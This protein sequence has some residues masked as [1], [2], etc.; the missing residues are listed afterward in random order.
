M[1]KGIPYL[2]AVLVA[3]TLSA[4][5]AAPVLALFEHAYTCLQGGG[6]L[7]LVR[8]RCQPQPSGLCTA[9]GAWPFWSTAVAVGLGALAAAR[10]S[11]WRAGGH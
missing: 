2:L 6:A 1:N 9:L 5:W 3:L 7:D 11:R 8:L 10:A 4:G